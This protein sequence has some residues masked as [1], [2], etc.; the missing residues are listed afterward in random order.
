MTPELDAYANFHNAH[1]QH[2]KVDIIPHTFEV[3]MTETQELAG[4]K[5]N[6]LH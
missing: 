1:N 2:R 3:V 4:N 5:P 6:Y